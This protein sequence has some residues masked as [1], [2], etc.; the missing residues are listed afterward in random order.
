M[1]IPS[2]LVIG[3]VD[4]EFPFVFYSI[5]RLKNYVLFEDIYMV[6]VW[7]DD[8]TADQNLLNSE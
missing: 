6:T 3:S 5:M 8:L 4:E 1:P 2:N 7:R